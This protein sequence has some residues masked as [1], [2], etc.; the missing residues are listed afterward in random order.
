VEALTPIVAAA[1]PFYWIPFA[2]IFIA[3]FI[4]LWGALREDGSDLEKVE[5]RE[6]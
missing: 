6:Q 2:F 4:A 5:E 1:S 3:L